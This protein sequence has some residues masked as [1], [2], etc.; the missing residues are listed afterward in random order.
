MKLC[1][2]PGQ[3]FPSILNKSPSRPPQRNK[4]LLLTRTFTS[5]SLSYIVLSTPRHQ[6]SPRQP[7]STDSNRHGTPLPLP[8]H[9]THVASL[10]IPNACS[11][12]LSLILRQPNGRIFGR[13]HPRR[14]SLACLAHYIL[15]C[16]AWFLD[17]NNGIGWWTDAFGRT[18]MSLLDMH[19]FL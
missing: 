13:L 7:P 3:S 18:A 4:T 16:Q 15:L 17:N 5:I 12:S 2:D 14:A 19:E 6:P 8:S 1:F 10:R 9:Y 11:R